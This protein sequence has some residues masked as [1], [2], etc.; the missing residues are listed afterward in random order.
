MYTQ[1][2]VPSDG[3]EGA[4]RALGP[5]LRL[6][7]ACQASVR[8]LGVAPGELQIPVLRQAL[9]AQ[10]AEALDAERSRVEAAVAIT[11]EGDVWRGIA[12]ALDATP[13][14]LVCMAAREPKRTAVFGGSTVDALLRE[15]AVPVLLVGPSADTRAFALTSPLL[16]CV[17]G[18]P[19]SESVLSIAASWSRAFDID[20]TVATVEHE[21]PRGTKQDGDETAG[22]A[23]VREVADRLAAESGRSVDCDVV[24]GRDAADA[25][26]AHASDRNVCAIVAATHGRTGLRRVTA[27]SVTASLIRHARQPLLIH[28]PAGLLR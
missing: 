3:S 18:S 20:V 28:R 16:V 9:E 10:L 19:T 11:H 23:Y 24:H 2:I 7:T 21:P 5:G 22:T 6:A 8:V 13:G 4:A 1:I 27:G 17:D 15:I 14:S 26:V 12:G 25:L